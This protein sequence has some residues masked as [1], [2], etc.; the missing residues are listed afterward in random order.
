MNKSCGCKV[1]YIPVGLGAQPIVNP[2][3]AID[4]C[5]LHR[6]APAMLEALTDIFAMIQSGELVRDIKKDGQSDWELMM[7]RFVGKLQKAGQALFQA[8]GGR[9]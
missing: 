6:A 9:E 3:D 5:P 2:L 7:T 8:K 4:F 1:I